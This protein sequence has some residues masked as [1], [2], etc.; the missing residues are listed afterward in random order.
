MEI[1]V[2]SHVKT[3]RPGR[4]VHELM[5]R[6]WSPYVFDGRA[7]DPDDLASIFE[8]AR[9][10][11]SSFNEQPWRY[12]VATRDDREEFERVAS[13]LL[14]ANRAWAEQ[15]AVLAL[16]AVSLRFGRNDKP[17]R[18]AQHDLGLASAG[19]TFEATARGL[20]VHQ[21]AG[22]LPDRARELFEIPEGFEVITALAIGHVGDP[23]AA[24]GGLG[25]RDRAERTRRPLDES[26]FSGRWG[27]P[28]L[29]P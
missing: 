23:D 6:R 21:M 7:V 1:S 26:V 4:P 13:C 8:A 5:I 11:P 19:L 25:D 17:N 28:G 16:G 29:K 18:V 24:A 14:D 27:R 15:A 10:A 20:S 12:I 22:I 2:M 3:A 9:W